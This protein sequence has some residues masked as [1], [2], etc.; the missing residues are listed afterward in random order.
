M[1]LALS[2]KHIQVCPK[3]GGGATK[4][5]K[6]DF[7]GSHLCVMQRNVFFYKLHPMIFISRRGFVHPHVSIFTL[8]I[9]PLMVYFLACFLSF[10]QGEL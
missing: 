6:P 5:T 8:Y 1:L 3:G 9:R 2:N 7:F 10:A 4:W